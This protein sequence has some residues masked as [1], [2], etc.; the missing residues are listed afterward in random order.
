MMRAVKCGLAAVTAAL[1]TAGCGAP[2]ESAAEFARLAGAGAGAD[3]DLMGPPA[4]AVPAADLIVRGTLVD[5][6]DG[7]EVAYPD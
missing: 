6:L 1:L 4:A 3:F 7:V 2:A 5:V